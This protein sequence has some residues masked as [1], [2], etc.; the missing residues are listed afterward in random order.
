MYETTPV[1]ITGT[2]VRFEP[3]NPHTIITLEERTAT[4]QIRR[5][6]VEG[7]GRDQLDRSGSRMDAPSPGDVIGFCAFP[8][9][10]AAE[11]S[12]MFPG[13]DFSARRASRELDGPSPQFVAGHVMVEPDGSKRLWEPH[14]ILSECI[15]SSD[16]DRQL[17]LDFLNSNRRARQAWCQQRRYTLIQSNASLAA[18]VEQINSSIDVPCR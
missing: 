2:V 17:W 13:V 7:P 5:W 15:R 6:G 3:V 16:D 4:G 14:G 11:L 10:P 1:W 9:K 18:F 8:Y 12:R